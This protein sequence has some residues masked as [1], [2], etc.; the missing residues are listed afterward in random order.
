M[1]NTAMKTDPQKNS[2]TKSV[3]ET[4]P[5]RPKTMGRQGRVSPTPMR[6]CLT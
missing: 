4:R 1:M 3:A 6:Q 5:S 2:Q